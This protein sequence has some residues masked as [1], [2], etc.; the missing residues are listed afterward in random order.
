[1]AAHNR[2]SI[3]TGNQSCYF[4]SAT[5]Q[6]T[7]MPSGPSGAD[8]PP[9]GVARSLRY[10]LGVRSPEVAS[11]ISSKIAKVIQSRRSHV[12]R[13]RDSRL[14][15]PGLLLNIHPAREPDIAVVRVVRL[16]APPPLPSAELLGELFGLTPSEASI[17]LALAGDM[18]LR[19]IADLRGSSQETVRGHVKVLLRKT[20]ASSQKQLVRIITQIG[21]SVA[22]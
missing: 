10:V 8:L 9:M 17:C 16:E 12:M 11:E 5:G 14:D 2:A 4:V 18:S 21:A 15:G 13:L 19:E 7:A 3:S 22:G 6:A 1:M 20:G